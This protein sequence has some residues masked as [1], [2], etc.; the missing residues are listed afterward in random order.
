MSYDE[1]MI[2]LQKKQ[3]LFH[4]E[5]LRKEKSRNE[6]LDTKLDACIQQY[7]HD[8]THPNDWK[9]SN[10]EKFIE[11]KVIVHVPNYLD[12]EV[13][14][15]DIIKKLSQ[16]LFNNV[17]VKRIGIAMCYDGTIDIN[18]LLKRP[19]SDLSLE[20]QD[21]FYQEKRQEISDAL[22]IAEENRQANAQ[23]LLEEEA[24]I[25]SWAVEFETEVFNADNW[26]CLPEP[27]FIYN[28]NIWHSNLR[29]E[30]IEKVTERM[31]LHPQFGIEY[32]VDVDYIR[33]TIK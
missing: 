5:E 2:E 32:L 14:A 11:K 16:L 10:D 31:K 30:F 12:N 7:L 6:Y 15:D 33:V 3:E 20:V 18:C 22:K 17:E 28:V 4:E 25:E 9:L 23:K 1:L 19:M 8:A 24:L 26:K 27:I 13:S 29:K 21:L